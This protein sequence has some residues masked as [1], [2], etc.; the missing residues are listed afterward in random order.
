MTSAE[1]K[2]GYELNSKP[3]EEVQLMETFPLLSS[4]LGMN[5]AFASGLESPLGR[6][7]RRSVMRAKRQSTKQ[8][9]ASAVSQA[10]GISK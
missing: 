3:T 8:I 2:F 9:N 4:L 10:K 1:K 5:F 6:L 7:R